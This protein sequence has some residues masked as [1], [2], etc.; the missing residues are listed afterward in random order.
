MDRKNQLQRLRY[1]LTPFFA[2]VKGEKVVTEMANELIEEAEIVDSL[3]RTGELSDLIDTFYL[4]LERDIKEFRGILLYSHEGAKNFLKCR[5]MQSKRTN[6]LKQVAEALLKRNA[7]DYYDKYE[8]E[9]H[10]RHFS[11]HPIE[12]LATA[13]AAVNDD[14]NDIGVVIG[15]EG[16]MYASMFSL[17]GFPLVNIHI[18]E[19]C[20]TE[21]RPY[22]ELDDISCI[23]GKRV[24]LIEDD[25][26][27]GKTLEKALSKIEAYSPSE[28]SVYL[29]TR[30]DKQK[31]E[32]VPKQIRRVYTVS[33]MGYEELQVEIEKTIKDLE[34]KYKIFKSGE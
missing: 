29:G 30:R 13:R 23:K 5:Q 28:V 26:V 14:Q 33:S 9:Q 16:F 27:T 25:V 11:D 19:Y 32:N 1:S 10:V 24:L 3:N 8:I 7:S 22:K 15:P 2:E 18:D 31:L 21:D 20:K 34:R 4:K 12:A 17:L 6:I